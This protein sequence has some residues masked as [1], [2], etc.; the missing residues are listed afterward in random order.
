M[1]SISPSS[2]LLSLVVKPSG[3]ATTNDLLA[4][5]HPMMRSLGYGN[6]GKEE[7]G[8]FQASKAGDGFFTNEMFVFAEVND[9]AVTINMDGHS[10]FG[11]KGVEQQLE[12]IKEQYE[13]SGA[14]AN[15]VGPNYAS[16]LVGTLLYTALPIYASAGLVVLMLHTAGETQAYRLVN[17]FLYATLGVIGAKTRF[18]VNERRKQRPIWKSILILLLVFPLFLSAVYFIFWAIDRWFA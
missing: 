10:I 18:W 1:V 11:L 12:K 9:S 13:N 3:Q 4:Q 5:F 6:F 17:V 7:E 2:P 15:I 8:L 14:I 16:A